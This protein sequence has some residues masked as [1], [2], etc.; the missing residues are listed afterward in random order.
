MTQRASQL[1]EWYDRE[2][3]DLPWRM[4]PGQTADPYKVW[5]SEIMLQQ[6]TVATV[7]SYYMAFFAKRPTVQDLGGADLDEVLYLWQG[8]GY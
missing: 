6:T 1:L 5:M 4:V 3:R 2:R 8:L 7:K